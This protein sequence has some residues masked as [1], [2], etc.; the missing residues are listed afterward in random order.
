VI[1][2]AAFFD[3]DGT[4]MDREPLMQQAVRD[5][6]DAAGLGYTD[7]ELAPLV[8]RAWQDVYVSLE[9]EERA[10]LTFGSF[11]D[12]V[13]GRAQLLMDDGYPTPVLA[14]GVEL[15]ERLRRADV[16]VW[17]VTGSLRREA[18]VAIRRLGIGTLLNGSLAAEEYGRGKPDPECYLTAADL[19]GVVDGDRARCLVV[20]DSEP[21]VRAG[22][23]AGMRVL[24]TSAANRPPDHPSHQ[25][26]TAAHVVVASL[27]DVDD[28]TMQALLG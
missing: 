3:L 14:G 12:S 10:G 27:A 5:I 18:D 15:I 26:L 11:I 6:T 21:G 16:P 28:A 1:P 22:V 8:G 2:A 9:I 17:L 20:E 25:D 13:M 7:A 23:A 4:L 24:A 19:A